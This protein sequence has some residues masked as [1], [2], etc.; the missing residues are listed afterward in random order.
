ME[1][2]KKF[3]SINRVKF[4]IKFCGRR[5]GDIP[6]MYASV[7]KIKKYLKWKSKYSLSQMCKIK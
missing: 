6:E 1:V 7:K 5:S 3:K 2:V 4:L